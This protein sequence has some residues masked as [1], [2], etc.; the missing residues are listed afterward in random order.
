[1]SEKFACV[2]SETE[3]KLRQRWLVWLWLWWWQEEGCERGTKLEK[4]GN[5]GG[6]ECVSRASFHPTP[7]EPR[8]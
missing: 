6:G 3:E 7:Q 8:I 5:G 1:M 2:Q 4:A